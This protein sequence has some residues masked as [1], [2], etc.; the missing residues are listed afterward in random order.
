MACGIYWR[1]SCLPSLLAQVNSVRTDPVQ[2]PLPGP[3]CQ[4]LRTQCEL[5]ISDSFPSANWSSGKISMVCSPRCILWSL[6]KEKAKAASRGLEGQKPQNEERK[7]QVELFH[8]TSGAWS[9]ALVGCLE[10]CHSYLR[11]K[12]VR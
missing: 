6:C 2:E 11:E 9:R 7:K 12:R 3:Q 8:T 4:E 5:A 10:V 1:R